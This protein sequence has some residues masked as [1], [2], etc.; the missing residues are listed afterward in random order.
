M[1]SIHNIPNH[2]YCQFAE[3]GNNELLQTHH[4][5]DLAKL[6]MPTLHECH[7]IQGW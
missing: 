7:Q 2:N 6:G 1:D 5:H 3:A 4:C